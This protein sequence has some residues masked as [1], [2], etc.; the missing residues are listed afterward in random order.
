MAA[1]APPGGLFGDTVF[2]MVP[3]A[4]SSQLARRNT[5]AAAVRAA[6]AT[7]VGRADSAKPEYEGR[8]VRLL[9]DP[10]MVQ[11]VQPGQ[12]V[13]RRAARAAACAAAGA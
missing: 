9:C 2:Y 8:V 12:P 3:V 5:V 4:E 1:A 6:G 7:L 13:R 11:H 10:Y